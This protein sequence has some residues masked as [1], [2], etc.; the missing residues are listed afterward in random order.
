M[1]PSLQQSILEA[2][3]DSQQWT[4]QFIVDDFG[5]S[6]DLSSAAKKSISST[7]AF[8]SSQTSTYLHCLLY[9]FDAFKYN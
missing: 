1:S 9:R 6:V 7:P 3:S 8:A 4:Q 5:N 2:F